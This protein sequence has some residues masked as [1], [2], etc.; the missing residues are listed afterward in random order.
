M[1]YGK[2]LGDD[3]ESCANGPTLDTFYGRL[4][5]SFSA[6]NLDRFLSSDNPDDEHE[7]N[8]SRA[9]AMPLRRGTHDLI[10]HDEFDYFALS[11]PLG[12]S[13]QVEARFTTRD[14]QL[15]LTL[16]TRSG[17]FIDASPFS[18]GPVRSFSVDADPGEYV[19]RVQ[20]RSGAGGR[21]TLNLGGD[22]PDRKRRR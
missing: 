16:Y 22:G 5:R 18:R 2:C 1:L 17:R 7:P 20:R 12:G 11:V 13:V 15:D 10:L 9:Q 3:E 8:N 4:D 21:Y 19:L 6:M 14:M